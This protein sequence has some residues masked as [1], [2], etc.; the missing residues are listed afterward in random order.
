MLPDLPLILVPDDKKTVPVDA[1]KELPVLKLKY[2]ESNPDSEDLITIS[3]LAPL[4]DLPEIRD[5][6]PPEPLVVS[7][8]VIAIRLPCIEF[9]LPTDNSTFP[10]LVL[11]EVPLAMDTEP[12]LLI[13]VPVNNFILPLDGLG[14]VV[15]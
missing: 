3:P 9:P 13:A 7:P 8:A 12:L 4:C 11:D 2:P 1:L 14:A 10:A 6:R 15:A 5:T